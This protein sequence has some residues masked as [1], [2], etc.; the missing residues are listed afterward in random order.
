VRG[1][2]SAPPR[3]AQ[4]CK[5]EMK[6]NVGDPGKWPEF[7]GPIQ[8]CGTSVMQLV[9]LIRPRMSLRFRV[10]ITPELLRPRVIELGCGSSIMAGKLIE[11]S[12]GAISA[13]T[14]AIETARAPAMVTIVP[15][16]PIG[17]EV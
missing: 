3:R 1:Q 7:G 6:S 2:D 13:S 15:S 9:A 4:V 12:A 17:E 10:A 5:N 16:V 11:Y 14:S 8:P